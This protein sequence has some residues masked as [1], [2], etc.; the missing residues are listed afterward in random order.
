MRKRNHT[1]KLI[2]GLL[3]VS[4]ASPSVASGFRQ[5]GAHV[6]GYVTYDIAQDSEDLLIDIYAPG[7]DVVG[8]EHQANTEAEK[9][10]IQDKTQLLNHYSSILKIDSAARCTVTDH[11]VNLLKTSVNQP[12]SEGVHNPFVEHSSHSSFEIKYQFHCQAPSKLDEIDTSW[13]KLF[14]ST[15]AIAANY[16]TDKGQNATELSKSHTSINLGD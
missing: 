4:I 8:F 16:F 15:K 3:F 9:K 1:H 12:V 10:E 5:H 14:P 7:M 2:Y 6:H 11:R 13:F